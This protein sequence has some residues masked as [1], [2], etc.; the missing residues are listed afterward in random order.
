MTKETSGSYQLL[1]TW[2]DPAC[3]QFP[4]LANNNNNNQMEYISCRNQYQVFTDKKLKKIKI[5]MF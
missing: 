4:K 3:E 1:N 2:K 5:D